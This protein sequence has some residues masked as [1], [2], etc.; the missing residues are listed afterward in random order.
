[1]AHTKMNN[2]RMLSD[3]ENTYTS[4][5]SPEPKL[6]EVDRAA[7]AKLI[8]KLDAMIVPPVR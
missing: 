6:I 4:A 3:S 2:G 8:R 7:E 1:M 5:A